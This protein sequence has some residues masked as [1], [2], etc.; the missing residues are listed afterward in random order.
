MEHDGNDLAARLSDDYG[1]WFARDERLAQGRM[2]GELHPYERLFSPV[3]I[4]AV[5]LKNRIVMGPMGNISVAD[6]SGRPS[7][8]MV[9]YFAER[10]RGGA[11]LLTSGLVPVNHKVDPAV[12]EPRGLSYF[13]GSTARAR[14]SPAG[15]TSP[16][17]VTPSAP[18]SSCSSRPAWAASARRSACSASTA[19]RCRHRGTATTTCRACPAAR[20]STMSAAR[21]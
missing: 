8:R 4:N 6:E 20:C 19:C 9:R 12:T 18:A 3:Q 1:S 2:S 14:S 7:D 21:S 16:P 17:A 11:G 15:A 10:A 5:T 13:P